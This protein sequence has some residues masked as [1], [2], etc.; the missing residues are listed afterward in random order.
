VV[1]AT[2][3]DVSLRQTVSHQLWGAL[4]MGSCYTQSIK[5]H[6]SKIGFKRHTSWAYVERNPEMGPW[7]PWRGQLHR[8][9]RT[10]YVC[11]QICGSMSNGMTVR[12]GPKK[13]GMMGRFSTIFAD[14]TKF[15]PSATSLACKVSR[16]K[17]GAPSKIGAT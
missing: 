13:F 15:G 3:K 12:R 1:E 6:R 8:N 5:A 17:K 2:S 10:A 14:R 9:M 16:F 7:G 4:E 11:C